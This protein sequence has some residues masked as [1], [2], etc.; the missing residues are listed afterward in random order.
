MTKDHSREGGKGQRE[1]QKRQGAHTRLR[2]DRK[3]HGWEPAGQEQQTEALKGEPGSGEQS[4]VWNVMP[5][6][7]GL[8]GQRGW[9]GWWVG[10]GVVV[11]HSLRVPERASG[12]DRR[13]NDKAKTTGP[14]G[15]QENKRDVKAGSRDFGK[16]GPRK[17]ARRH[18]LEETGTTVVTR[19]P[20][21]QQVAR[22]RCHR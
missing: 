22:V 20:Q 19:R 14:S 18:T 7:A 21:D 4:S 17:R 12:R 15:W 10:G 11:L 1:R 6:R 13:F 3:G 2:S 16:E 9:V 5:R 8:K